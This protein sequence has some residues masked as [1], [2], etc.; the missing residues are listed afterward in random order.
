MSGSKPPVD[1]KMDEASSDEGSDGLDAQIEPPTDFTQDVDMSGPAA[2][3]AETGTSSIKPPSA[4]LP[5][6]L[7]PAGKGREQRR[8]PYGFGTGD[9]PEGFGGGA[10]KIT[11]VDQGVSF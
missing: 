5:G 7:K 8:A 6:T 1:F 3:A 2:T 9:R 4:L 11:V 10:D